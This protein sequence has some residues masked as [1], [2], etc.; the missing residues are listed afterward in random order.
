MFDTL[1]TK[2]LDRRGALERSTEEH[3]IQM[4]KKVVKSTER[5]I[6]CV[7]PG[8]KEYRSQAK[9]V[10]EA[11]VK[12]SEKLKHA[13]R[14]HMPPIHITYPNFKAAAESIANDLNAR[15]DPSR[16]SITMHNEKSTWGQIAACMRDPTIMHEFGGV[17]PVSSR[18]LK[19]HKITR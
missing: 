5:A 15:A 18:L 17:I 14:G 16:A 4:Y 2:L 8:S 9:R 13:V 11:K 12:D 19:K 3:S 1:Q 7:T 6:F 10:F